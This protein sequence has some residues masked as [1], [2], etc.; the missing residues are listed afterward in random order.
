MLKSG[1]PNLPETPG[2]YFFCK[3]KYPIYIGKAVNLKRRVKSYFDLDLVGK[4]ARMISKADNFSFI[5]VRSELEA[6]LLEAGFIKKYL[7]QYNVVAKD[8]KHPLYITITK[9]RF[10]KV[11]TT[12]KNGTFGP[13]PSSK[14]VYAVLRMIRKIFPYSDHKIGKRPCLYSHIG[15]CNPCPNSITD[16]QIPIYK[17]NI[18]NIKLILEGKFKILKNFL[19]K[20]MYNYSNLQKYEEAQEIKNKINLLDYITQPKTPPFEYIKNPNLYEDQ[21][22]NELK[23]L[24][25]IVKIKNLHRIECFDI[26][27]LQGVSATASMVVFIDG[28]AEKSQ[29]R[30][31]KIKQ[32]KSKSDYHSMKEIAKRRSQH[33]KDWGVPNLI[34]VDGNIGQVNKFREHIKNIPIVGIAKNPDRLIINAENKVISQG[35]TLL[36]VGRIRDEAHRF[37]RRYHHGLISKLYEDHT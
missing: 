18:K 1:L 17:Q 20:Q 7:P 12:R 28:I 34:I 31:F 27:H 16:L 32:K 22:Q 11:I 35:V 23:E 8:D 13:F 37:A 15:L 30:H 19:I 33:F 4:T 2:V 36:F 26:A 6:L 9:D 21:R 29:Y 25:K 5:Q 3:G 14:N 10:P 24:S